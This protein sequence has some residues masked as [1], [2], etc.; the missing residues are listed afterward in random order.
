M[1][2]RS[3]ILVIVLLWYMLLMVW[4]SYNVFSKYCTPIVKHVIILIVFVSEDPTV[5]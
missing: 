2:T 3:F 1:N 4:C 5:K